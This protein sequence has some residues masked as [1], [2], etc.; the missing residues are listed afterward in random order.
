M[1]EMNRRVLLASVGLSTAALAFGASGVTGEEVAPRDS[2][3]KSLRDSLIGAW[4]LVSCVETDVKSGEAYRP[5]G[6]KPQG[7]LLYT[8]DGY[9]SAQLSALDRPHFESGDM[10]RGKPKEYVTAV[11]SYLAY[12]GPYYVDEARRIVEHEMF[13]SLFPNWQGQRQVRV[14]RLDEKALQLSTNQ[15]QLFNGTL[16][17]ATIVWRRA[18]ANN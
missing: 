16:K 8:P 17:T 4:E 12:T 2:S 14:V 1:C 10:Y 15:P 9:M 3:G 11:R 18:K 6:D 13:V 7:L 5:M